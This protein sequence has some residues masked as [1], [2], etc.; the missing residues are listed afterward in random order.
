VPK[1]LQFNGRLVDLDDLDAVVF[2]VTNIC[3]CAVKVCRF[4]GQT[5]FHYSN[6]QHMLMVSQICPVRELKLACLLHDVHECIIGDFLTPVVQLLGPD[7][8]WKLTDIKYALDKVVARQF[9]CP[10]L[11]DPEAKKIIKF[12]DEEMTKIEA[13]F[14]L[15]NWWTLFDES[16]IIVDY[17]KPESN[18]RVMKRWKNKLY[19]LMNK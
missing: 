15:E 14:L 13:K 8:K 17:L 9:N 1:L 10:E 12:Y 11:I 16:E 3:Q 19:R 7:V 6:L 4:N 18:N 2:E 5:K